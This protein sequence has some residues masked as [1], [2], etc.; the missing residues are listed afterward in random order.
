VET[1][2]VATTE[3]TTTEKA[4]EAAPAETA[5]TEEAPKENFSLN[6]SASDATEEARKRAER[7]KR[8]GITE[9]S[10]VDDAE[11]KKAERAQRFG[12]ETGD[13]SKSLD[14]ALPERERRSKRGREEDQGGRDTKRQTTGGRGGRRGDR[15]QNQND[16]R[17]RGRN[18]NQNQNQG[19]AQGGRPQR[20]KKQPAAI[21]PA[22]KAKMDARAKRFAA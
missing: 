17:G 5:A 15:N 20:T 2:A 6:L 13:L 7:A 9:A 14:A 12:V 19:Q 4:A 3:A 1:P 8:F 21:D 11:K 10:T 18:Q 16:N 22:D